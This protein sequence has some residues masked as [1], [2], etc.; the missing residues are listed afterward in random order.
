MASTAC[1][2]PISPTIAA[3]SSGSRTSWH[4]AW[5]RSRMRSV[6][7]SSWMGFTESSTG[8]RPYF[9]QA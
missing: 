2:R 3:V 9:S 5:I 7:R 8:C 4:G 1:I 6:V